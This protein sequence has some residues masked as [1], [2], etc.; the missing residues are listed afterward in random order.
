MSDAVTSSENIGDGSIGYASAASDSPSDR[1]LRRIVACAAILDGGAAIVAEIVH[2]ALAKGWLASPKYMSWAFE[3]IY[4]VVN[5]VI[6]VLLSGT[7][8][9]GGVLLL[10]RNH[11]SIAVLRCS[12][13]ASLAFGVFSFGFM[14]YQD[15]T[16]ANYWSTFGAAAVQ[17]IGML[18]SFWL[19]T[20][21]G[22]LTL[23][24]LARRLV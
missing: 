11:A 24:P 1:L 15:R 19:P 23:P 2:V 4:G 22:L 10:R 7:L 9:L 3:G 12:M 6:S 14:L 20:I 17:G 16:W 8:L 21:I 13:I 5:L 18:R